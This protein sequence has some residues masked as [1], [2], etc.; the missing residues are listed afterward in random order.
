[1]NVLEFVLLAWVGCTAI[2]WAYD[3][4]PEIYDEQKSAYRVRHPKKDKV[5]ENTVTL[6]VGSFDPDTT[7]KFPKIIKNDLDI[8]FVMNKAPEHTP[9]RRH[10]KV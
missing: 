5:S 7:M 9:R 1:M 3:F 6:A 8:V 2:A 4:G 10:A